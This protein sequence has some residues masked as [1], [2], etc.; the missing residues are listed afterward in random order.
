MLFTEVEGT[1]MYLYAEKD[2]KKEQFS[3]EKQ[4]VQSLLQ[5]T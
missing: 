5:K 3:R 1:L 2:C 4:Y